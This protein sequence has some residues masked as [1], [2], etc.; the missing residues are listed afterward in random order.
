MCDFVKIYLILFKQDYVSS[1][2][3]TGF[4][5]SDNV[6]F[7]LKVSLSCFYSSL[8][9]FQELLKTNMKEKKKKKNR[10]QSVC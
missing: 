5:S 6:S 7:C 10:N 9:V 1:D 4:I 8:S 2:Y 3:N